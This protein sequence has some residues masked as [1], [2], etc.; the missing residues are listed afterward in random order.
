MRA[1]CWRKIGTN[2]SRVQ[3][4]LAVAQTQLAQSEQAVDVAR[5]TLAQFA[6]SEPSGLNLNPETC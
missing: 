1:V 4:E 3:A 2:E 5:S 6:G